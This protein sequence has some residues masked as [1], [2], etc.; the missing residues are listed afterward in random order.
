MDKKQKGLKNLKPFKKGQS[1]NPGGR[2]KLPEDIKQARRLNQ[3]EVSRVFNRFVNMPLEELKLALNDP[4]TKSL[5]LMIGKVMIN[6]MK[7]G[8]YARFN[9]I[10]DRMVGKVTEKVEHKLPKPTVIKLLG[11]AGTL[12]LGNEEQS[13]EDE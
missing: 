12:V 7:D 9:F 3:L 8:D 11:D 13:D 5:E 1:G 10:L 6:C 4:D 2:P